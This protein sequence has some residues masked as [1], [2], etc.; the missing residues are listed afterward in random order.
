[1]GSGGFVPD[2]PVEVVIVETGSKTVESGGLGKH[3]MVLPAGGLPLPDPVGDQLLGRRH[4]DLTTL[5]LDQPEA[6]PL[7][8]TVEISAG[9]QFHADGDL[10]MVKAPAKMAPAILPQESHRQQRLGNGLIGACNEV[11]IARR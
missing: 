9:D 6:G 11:E 2:A 10:R 3:F 8:L 4:A 5:Q 1:M 7:R